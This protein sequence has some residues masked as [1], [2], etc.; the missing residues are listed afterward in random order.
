M[1]GLEGDKKKKPGTEF[2]FELEKDWKDQKKYKN[3]QEKIESRIQKIKEFLR[4]G[5]DKSEFES[6]T[7]LL[8]GYHSLL[9]VMS[10]IQIKK[11]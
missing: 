10:R 2:V 5:D 3:I 8:Y 9:K 7:A 1:F 11:G 4:A 6:L